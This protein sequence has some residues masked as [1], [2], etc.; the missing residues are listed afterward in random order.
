MPRRRRSNSLIG[1]ARARRSG[2]RRVARRRSERMFGRTVETNVLHQTVAVRT[3]PRHRWVSLMLL[4][5]LGG[6]A[7]WLFMSN[8][9]YVFDAHIEGTNLLTAA[10]VYML[11]DI[12]GWHIFWIRPDEVEARLLNEPTIKQAEVSVGLPNRVTIR[13]EERQPLAVWQ[14]NGESY[15]VD[16]E[17][18]LFR[19]RG[20]ASEA[21][22]I[23]D[24]R[25]VPVQP[26]M[27][28]DPEAVR[29]VVELHTLLPERRAFDWR[30]AAGVSFIAEGGWEV[31]FGDRHDLAWKVAVYRKFAETLAT[32]EN[33]AVLDL[34]VPERP[35]YQ[36]RS[37]E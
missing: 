5:L 23:R 11:A 4:T 13:I 24:M 36:V 2:R 3:I 16:E 14:S 10:E 22:V 19:L 15:F 12:D 27:Q 32:Q 31:R 8:T 28:V 33:I 6:I 21:L 18:V 25:D 26:G 20:D 1:N 17:G 7:Y 37:G 34:T 29:T 9:F 30:P 35:F